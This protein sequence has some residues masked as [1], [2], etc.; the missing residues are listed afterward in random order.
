MINTCIYWHRILHLP[1]N[2]PLYNI[3]QSFWFDL[4]KVNMNKSNVSKKYKLSIYQK[5]SVL[6]IGF[7]NV[8]KLN[9]INRTNFGK[10]KYH[11]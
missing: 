6:W 1:D 2:N 7:C 9:L 8:Q 4:W 10:Y 5:R 3:I 11:F